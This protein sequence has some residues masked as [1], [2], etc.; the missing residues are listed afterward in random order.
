MEY[1]PT[2]ELQSKV[3]L[4]SY[5]E[6]TRDLIYFEAPAY[7]YAYMLY[8]KSEQ[9]SEIYFA[10][11]FFYTEKFDYEIFANADMWLTYR[12]VV[13]DGFIMYSPSI[14]SLVENSTD[15]SEVATHNKI[16]D[17]GWPEYIMTP[18]GS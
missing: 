9:R 14:E 12:S 8:N 4:D 13:R 16:Y 5:R 2:Q 11:N 6:G 15:I 3:F 10:Y 17:S 18:R 7:Y 1:A